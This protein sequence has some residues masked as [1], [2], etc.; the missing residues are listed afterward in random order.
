MLQV[1]VRDAQRPQLQDQVHKPALELCK[2]LRDRTNA[3]R[4]LDSTAAPSSHGIFVTGSHDL[5]DAHAR[6]AGT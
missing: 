3:L 1:A 5:A 6:C 4:R 2:L